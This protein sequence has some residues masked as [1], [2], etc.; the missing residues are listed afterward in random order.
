MFFNITVQVDLY[1][2]FCVSSKVTFLEFSIFTC[3]IYP[4]NSDNFTPDHTLLKFEQ[5]W[6]F[7]L[8]GDASK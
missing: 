2:P 6:S 7:S 4:K 5:D 3:R 8:P 1:G